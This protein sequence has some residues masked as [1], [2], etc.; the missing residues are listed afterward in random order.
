MAFLEEMIMTQE[1][2]DLLLKD[3][4]A[5]LPYKVRVKQG[6]YNHILDEI[7]ARREVFD[8]SF[9]F[10]KPYLFPL[11]SMTEEQ[12]RYI[13]E[14]Y[15]DISKIEYDEFYENA[16]RQNCFIIEYTS[17]IDFIDWLNKNYFDYRD[18]IPMGL[19]IDAS[20]LNIY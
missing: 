9:A 6:G 17:I 4:C 16:M 14:H 1:E 13:Y 18:L 11:S 8:S 15:V 12:L 2:R 3:L 5:R 10:P 20:G 7:N 19:A